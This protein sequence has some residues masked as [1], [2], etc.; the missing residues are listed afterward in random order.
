MNPSKNAP[1]RGKKVELGPETLETRSLLTGG[2]GNLIAILPGNIATAKEVGTVTFT[3]S[4]PHFTIPKGRVTLGID[5][6]PDAVATFKPQISSVEDA[7]G[8]AIR[9]TT[10]ALFNPGVERNR[11]TGD[12]RS[13][14]MLVPLTTPRGDALTSSTFTVKIA[15]AEDSTGRYLLGF[16]LPGDANGAI[17]VRRDLDS[18]HQLAK[19]LLGL[20]AGQPV[21]RAWPANR[22]EPAVGAPSIGREPATVEASVLEIDRACA[23]RALLP[24]HTL[25]RQPRAELAPMESRNCP[26]VVPVGPPWRRRR[27]RKPP[28]RRDF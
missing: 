11:D 21:P 23:V 5:I 9:G 19:A 7:P 3:L 10:R 22:P 4:K 6:V 8:R 26:R 13:S 14:A 12:P 17:R 27:N 15:G 20:R 18:V 2:T 25:G 28:L 16:Y 24:R 1:R